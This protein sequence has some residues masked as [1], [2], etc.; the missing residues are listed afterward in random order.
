[1]GHAETAALRAGHLIMDNTRSD[2][3]HVTVRVNESVRLSVIVRAAN[4]AL[5]ARTDKRAIHPR[6]SQDPEAGNGRDQKR[7]TTPKSRRA[8]L[9]W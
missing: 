2:E 9:R 1:M 6:T 7:P 5:S 4:Q 8:Q 3:P